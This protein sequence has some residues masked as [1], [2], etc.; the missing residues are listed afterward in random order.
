MSQSLHTSDGGGNSELWIA[1]QECSQMLMHAPVGVFKS[2]PN[3]RYLAANIAQARMYGYDSPEELIGSV[4]DI[5]RQMYADPRDREELERL[6]QQ[7]GQVLNHE[8]RMLRKDGSQFWVS[9]NMQVVRD[10]EGNVQYYYGF[11]TDI[12]ERKQVEEEL[13]YQKQLLETIINGT[14]DVLA[15][16]YPDHSVERYNQAGYE[17]LG[18]NPEEVHGRKCF[19]L[20][21]RDRA[22]SPCATAQALQ[23]RK[24]AEIE[25]FVPELEAYLDCRSTPVLDE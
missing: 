20:M 19:E 21:G 18:L 22:C 10:R 1:P 3:G 9:R 16:Q 2:T 15:I 5:A 7:Q 17:L 11:S 23:T 4:T 14:P 24:P 13:R 25:K 12:T 6:L 8:C